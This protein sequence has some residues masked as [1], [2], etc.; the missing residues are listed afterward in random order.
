MS[1]G[2]KKVLILTL[3]AGEN[4]LEK[5][6]ESLN[7]QTYKNWEQ[8]IF[9]NLPNLEAHRAL[10]KKIMEKAD[11]YDLFIKLDADMVLKNEYILEK[12][13][14]IF[15]N[16]KELDHAFFSVRDWFSN[17]NIFGLH[18]FS[19]KAWWEFEQDKLLV[20]PD[21]KIPGKK[22]VFYGEPSPVAYHSPDP[23]LEEAFLFGYHRG[24]KVKLNDRILKD[25]FMAGFQFRLLDAVWKAFCRNNDQRR[26]Y[27]LLGAEVALTSKDKIL[28]N[29]RELFDK[30]DSLLPENKHEYLRKKWGSPF[31]KEIRKFTLYRLY[32][33]HF[34]V[35]KLLRIGNNFIKRV[36]KLKYLFKK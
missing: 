34:Y 9:T 15:N 26:M 31:F 25:G 23:S 17:M 11:D 6:K 18:V 20:D 27:A 12:I 35:D 30:V 1:L 4:E 10:Y 22:E 24:L 19:D 29:K 14:T 2:Q 13:V 16:Q 8:I 5:S 28:T 33:P 32:Y 3:Y 21:P 36:K 7:N